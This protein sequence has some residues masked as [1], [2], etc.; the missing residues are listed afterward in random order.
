[1]TLEL[2]LILI[3]IVIVIWWFWKIS[4]RP[5]NFSDEDWRDDAAARRE[6]EKQ[7]REERNNGK[8]N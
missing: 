4:T 5:G 6:I 3:A 7:L 1:M 8:K 2:A